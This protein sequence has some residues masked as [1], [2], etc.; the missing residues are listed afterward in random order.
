MSES[1]NILRVFVASPSGLDQE[2]KAIREV[3]D[4]INRRNSSYW[5]IQFQAVGWEDTI[6]GNRRA[7]EIINRDLE[8][9]DYFFGVLADHWGSP[10]NPSKN[11]EPGYTSG[12]Q[13]EY[14]LAQRLFDSGEMGDILLFFKEVTEERKRDV[15]PSLKKVLEFQQ[16][17]RDERKPFYSEFSTLETFKRKI[18]DVLSGVGW[19]VATPATPS[20]IAAPSDLTVNHVEPSVNE[21]SHSDRYFLSRQPRE[22]LS[23]IAT[24][25]SSYSSVSNIDIARLRLISTAVRRPGNDATSIGVHDANLLFHGRSILNLSDFEKRALLRIGL[26]CME[27]QNVPF[28]FWCDGDISVVKSFIED[29]MTSMDPSEATCALQ[30]AEIFGHEAPVFSPKVGRAY[31]IAKWFEDD[32]AIGL[33]SAA[34]SYLY[35]WGI[36]EDIAIL[37]QVRATK[38]GHQATIVDCIIIGIH[39]RHSQAMGLQGAVRTRSG[40]HFLPVAGNIANSISATVNPCAGRMCEVEG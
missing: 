31:W 20:G 34:E 33:R 5:G 2:R 9:C 6:G 11:A 37:R 35:R 39:F 13:E 23:T 38:S 22:F 36:P 19:K 16:K 4:D 29:S 32:Q 17:V 14:E 8:T 15:G 12:F 30:I 24:K 1:H 26:R 18:A 40:I 25:N 7:Q 10:P 27:H 28:W 21:A 3:I